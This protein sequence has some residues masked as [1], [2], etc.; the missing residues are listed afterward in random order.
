MTTST[1]QRPGTPRE[2]GEIVKWY[3]RAR[4]FPQ[5]IGRTPDGMQIWGGPYTY[6]QVGVGAALLVVGGKTASIWGQFGTIGNAL[7]LIGVT[8]AAVLAVGRLP[9][10]GRNPLSVGAGILRAVMS[11]PWGRSGDRRIQF[12]KPRA[13]R[14]RITIRE[15]APVTEAVEAEQRQPAELPTW[16]PVTRHSP[17]LPPT[18]RPPALSGVQRLLVASCVPKETQ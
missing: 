9:A 8:Y 11:P 1:D 6:T 13:V 18:T 5:L 16:R 15:T 2:E 17:L 14:T 12:R 3:T 4:R 10:G 7:I